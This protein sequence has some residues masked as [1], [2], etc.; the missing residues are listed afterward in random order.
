MNELIKL[1]MGNFGEIFIPIHNKWYK[2]LLNFHIHY[3][4]YILFQCQNILTAVSF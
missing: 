2:Y 3:T 1:E 4:I